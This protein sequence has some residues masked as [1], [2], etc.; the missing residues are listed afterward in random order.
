MEIDGYTD[1]EEIGRGGYAVVYRAHQAAFGRTVA[2]KV[3]TTVGLGETERLRFEREAL[4]M[5]RL[6]WHPNIVIVHE[7]GTTEAGLPYIVEEFLEGGSLG[8]RLR[9]E[10]PADP[11]DAL[12]DLVQL[13]A[14]THTA[15]EAD[16]LHRDIKPDNALIDTFGRVK[17]A[18]FG[19]AAVNGSTLTATGMI[20]AT[21][22]HA[23]PEVLNGD[24]ATFQADVYSLGSTLY[25][26]L[27]GAP[28]FVRGGEESI[29]PLVVRVTSEPVPDLTARGIPEAVARPVEAAMAK[30]PADRPSS[31]LELGKLLQAAQQQLGLRVTE[32]AVRGT[33]PSRHDAT[34][35]GASAPPPVVAATPPP[36]V[37]PA[38][39]PAVVA[40]P[41]SGIDSGID[42]GTT[43]EEPGAG[44]LT[45]A[46]GV[47]S[48]PPAALTPA[49]GSR[50][51]APLAGAP[52]RQARGRR[53]RLPVVL[54][55]IAAAVA[56]V[57][58]AVLLGGSGDDGAGPDD[59]RTADGVTAGL[60]IDAA[61][62]IPT[63]PRPFRVA[64]GD[65]AAWVTDSQGTAVDRIDLASEDVQSIDVGGEP[66]GV[67]VNTT[68]VWV[69][70]QT[71]GGSVVLIDPSTST[72]VT[73]L[74]VGDVARVPAAT[75]ARVWVTNNA[76][77]TVSLID[78]AS[79]T[80]QTAVAVPAGPRGVVAADDGV[81]VA[82]TDEGV[83]SR[84]DPD[85]GGVVAEIPV[86]GSPTSLALTDDAVWVTDGPNDTVT[87]IDRA[88]DAVTQTIDAGDNPGGMAAGAGFVY[89][90]NGDLGTVTVIDAAS[91][92]VVGT[93][94]VGAEPAGLA[95]TEDHLWVAVSA[96]DRV[97]RIPFG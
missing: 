57:L 18:D 86:G 62:S 87:R 78:V 85:T 96:E 56:A 35:L 63:G 47:V 40:P 55:V 26:L 97:L 44:E 42:S 69:V 51:S 82:S 27:T 91:N 29:V 4:A 41:P 89:V 72:P 2:I 68:G 24:R 88:G 45:G 65:D 37:P 43:T 90:A 9:S 80:V 23:A 25:E 1:L 67:D 31:A 36:A 13:C 93:V 76:E 70:T 10:G 49:P 59:A 11:T 16:L 50:P 46:T 7:T 66:V 33:P 32:L 34:L 28:P 83:V 48:V 75:D 3:L 77:D 6:S 21:L 38:P 81:W 64:I 54:V 14:A 92:E 17:L 5:G 15:H 30:D 84:L 8:D 20:T 53:S 74:R 60:D 61:S 95:V 22:A 79:R 58:A 52:D 94:A 73:R 39:T 19:I 71:D 12:A